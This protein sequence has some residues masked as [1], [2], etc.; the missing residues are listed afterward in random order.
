MPMETVLI[1]AAIVFAFVVFA[2]TLAWG[3][4]QTRDLPTHKGIE[5]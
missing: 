5:S 4:F 3:S 2:A 1:L